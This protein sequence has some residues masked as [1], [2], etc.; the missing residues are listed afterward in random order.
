MPARLPVRANVAG[1]NDNCVTQTCVIAEKVLPLKPKRNFARI[2]WEEDMKKEEI[3]A[4]FEQFEQAACEVNQ[5]KCWS[6][7]ELMMKRKM[8]Y[9]HACDAHGGDKSGVGR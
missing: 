4:L 6:A 2:K 5:V 3:L 9:A 8:G 1:D 7:R